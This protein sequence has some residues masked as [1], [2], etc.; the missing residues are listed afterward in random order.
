MNQIRKS[1]KRTH[2][3][4][5]ELKSQSEV[6]LELGLFGEIPF[7]SLLHIFGK[8]LTMRAPMRSAM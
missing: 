4:S 5:N 6:G 2:E 1:A 3:K 8:H 7:D